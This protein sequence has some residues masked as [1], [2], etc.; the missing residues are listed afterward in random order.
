MVGRHHN[1]YDTS[2]TAGNRSIHFLQAC[3][4]LFCS[5]IAC[6]AE[7]H[8][9]SVTMNSS[10]IKAGGETTGKTKQQNKISF[11]PK[12]KVNKIIHI[13]EYTDDE[14]NAT[15]YHRDEMKSVRQQLRETVKILEEQPTA[16]EF[17]E[18]N[19]F[20]KRGAE[21]RTSE[22]A[23]IR[24]R[25][26]NIAWDALFDAQ[27]AQ[28]ED[29]VFDPEVLASIYSAAT[30]HCQHA[31]HLL[32]LKDQEELNEMSWSHLDALDDCTQEMSHLDLEKSIAD[33]ETSMSD[34]GRSLREFGGDQSIKE[35][36][37]KET[38]SGVATPL[39]AKR[40]AHR[41]L[42]NRAA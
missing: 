10:S 33:L 35:R 18:S 36:A 31:A 30:T 25:N 11:C 27:D 22:G 12:V 14:I 26:K 9:L 13:N 42:H 6:I 16:D 7:S 20:S 29:G 3:D 21:F 8:R 32:A 41:P 4:E 24:H 2:A 28:F 1:I 34:L 38:Y 39:S 19:S 15:Y 5:F 37:F 40:I 17:K 23:R